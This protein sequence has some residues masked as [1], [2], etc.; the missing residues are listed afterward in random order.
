[1]ATTA[2]DNQALLLQVSANIA[3]LEKQFNKAAG[4]VDKQ[5]TF[6]ERRAKQMGKKLED[7][8]KIDIGK[9]L[10]NVFDSSRLKVMDSGIARIGLFGSALEP[11]GPLGFA[12]AAGIAAVGV[13]LAGAR[14]AARFADDIGD[15]ANRLHVTTDALQEFR[16]ANRAAGGEVGDTDKALESFSVSL[17]KAQQGL[18]KGQR[19]FLALGFSKAQIKSFKDA[20]EALGAVVERISGLSSVQQDAIIDQLGL[21]GIKPLIAA[22]ADE[23]SQLRD[24]AHK[25]GV[26]MDAELVKRG[27]ELNDQFE[28][29]QQVI[30]VQLKSAL[31]DLGPILVGLLGLVADMAKFAGEVADQFRSIDDKTLKGL[32]DTRQRAV[33]NNTNINNRAAAGHALS[34][35]E[36]DVRDRN[37][38]IIA[39]VDKQ[40]AARESAKAA[41]R[42][43]AGKVTRSLLDT[44]KTG[45]SKQKDQTGRGADAVNSAISSGDRAVLQALLGLTDDI[46]AR[47]SIQR[48]I[49]DAELKQ[50]MDS[51][52]K[53][54][55][56]IEE[57]NSSKKKEQL[58]GL[59]TARAREI[60]ADAIKRRAIEVERLRELDQK[61][62]ERHREKAGYEIDELRAQQDLAT[63]RQE[64]RKIE[65]E[66]L[67]RQKAI[68]D[69]A[70]AN[71]QAEK[72]RRADAADPNTVHV[73]NDNGAQ[74]SADATY[75]SEQA[76]V[77]KE[78]EGPLEAY[79]RALR[80][81]NDV[82]QNTA[83]D[84]LE[85]FNKG[86]I[87]VALNSAKAGDVMKNVLNK[88]LSDIITSQIGKAEA[89]IFD[90]FSKKKQGY[91][92]GTSN[93]ARGWHP[94]GEKG[95]EWV[96]FKGGEGVTSNAAISSMASQISGVRASAQVAGPLFDLRGAVV[97]QDLLD[98]MNAIGRRSTLS[99]RAMANND[100]KRSFSGRQ[101][102]LSKGFV[103]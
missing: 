49:A 69:E 101:A 37:N 27:G 25:V 40:L 2:E 97:T 74:K 95:V 17:G 86:V 1:M 85:A 61:S 35:P 36:I 78:T 43:A 75:G 66:I 24:E 38:A 20:E 19:P 70:R 45:G 53:Q 28:T 88:I 14:E 65:L 47:A 46:D 72:Q 102:A 34:K 4:I 42:E 93:A 71:E 3:N 60:E 5:S 50:A 62:L 8:S 55:R 29:V 9:A 91:A 57:G 92:T 23:M 96:N 89:S 68:D 94:V 48:Q 84:G 26:V 30:D 11:L 16:Y 103:L 81:Q 7:A 33:D 83:V 80:E 12:A 99:A 18:A 13:A 98:Q 73:I 21:E 15:A 59:E 51:L 56:E 64:R 76:R 90:L 32:K 39:N 77:L 54:K 41:E 87:D 63:T 31:V 44:S 79:I 67:A 52:D 82:L 22:G 100:A 6:M 10:D 58:A